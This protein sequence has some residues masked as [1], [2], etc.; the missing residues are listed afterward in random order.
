MAEAYLPVSSSVYD[1][2]SELHKKLQE[3]YGNDV[4]ISDTL[5]FLGHQFFVH[6][7][8][9]EIGRI[10][11]TRMS[12]DNRVPPWLNDALK[13]VGLHIPQ[14]A[15]CFI[16]TNIDV[17]GH[18]ASTRWLIDVEGANVLKCLSKPEAKSKEKETAEGK[19]PRRIRIQ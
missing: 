15:T 11:L 4:T 7:R 13:E 9:L 5:D 12:V 8:L 3:A 19:K 6:Q 2:V 10:M 16:R 18:W 1:A 17:P 14:D